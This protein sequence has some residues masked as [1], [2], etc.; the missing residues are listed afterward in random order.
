MKCMLNDIERSVVRCR[1]SERDAS[2]R[3]DASQQYWVLYWG[4]F[5]AN[6][7]V[8]L[9]I[10]AHGVGASHRLQLLLQADLGIGRASKAVTPDA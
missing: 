9:A 3:T 7:S 2:S 6:E 10:A 4:G 8:D 5:S 1:I